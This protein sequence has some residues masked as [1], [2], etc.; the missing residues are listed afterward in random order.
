MKLVKPGKKGN[1]YSVSIPYAGMVTSLKCHATSVD[2]A[3]NVMRA[4]VM[5]GVSG[6]VSVTAGGRNLN[7]GFS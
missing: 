1:N 7:V 5:I 3:S 4:Y 2:S 6:L